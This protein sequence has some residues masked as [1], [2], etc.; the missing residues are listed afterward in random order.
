[1]LKVL[2]LGGSTKGKSNNKILPVA[3]KNENTVQ[4]SMKEGNFKAL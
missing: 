1:M 4:D 2:N 3:D